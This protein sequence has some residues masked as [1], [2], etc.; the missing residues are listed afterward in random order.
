[1]GCNYDLNLIEYL[2]VFDH[3]M[4]VWVVVRCDLC[5]CVLGFVEVFSG[6]S[7]GINGPRRYA[8]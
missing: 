6:F 8:G 3:F 1:M 7:T 4:S 5:G 2:R